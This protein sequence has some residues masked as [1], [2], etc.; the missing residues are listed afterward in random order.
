VQESEYP[1]KV[2]I[3]DFQK[4]NLG[5]ATCDDKRG[6]STSKDTLDRYVYM[7]KFVKHPTDAEYRSCPDDEACSEDDT[8]SIKNTSTTHRDITLVICGGIALVLLLLAAFIFISL[9][10]EVA[11][12]CRGAIPQ[13]Y[14]GLSIKHDDSRRP[15]IECPVNSTS[16]Q[17]LCSFDLLANG[18]IPT[19]CFDAEMHHDFVDGKSYGF[20]EDIKGTIRV[21]QETIM[22][23]DIAS[24]PDGLWVTF[25][26][27]LHHCRYLLNGSIRATT[28]ESPAILDTFLDGGHMQHCFGLLDVQEKPS[29]IETHVKAFFVSHKCFIGRFVEQ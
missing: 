16:L 27:H 3:G 18:W 20:F 10:T 17:G 21:Q 11:R 14:A 5:L 6:L 8:G 25:E 19:P 24:Y 9:H 1:I 22:Q 28:R 23:G 12:A 26:E 7:A 13:S 4:F 29:H 2:C 15:F